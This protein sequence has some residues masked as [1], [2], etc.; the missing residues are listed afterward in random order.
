[1]A[2]KVFSLE[3]K[4]KHILYK[5]CKKLPDLWQWDLVNGRRGLSKSDRGEMNIQMDVWV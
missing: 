5:S 2:G 1:M 3:L 4:A